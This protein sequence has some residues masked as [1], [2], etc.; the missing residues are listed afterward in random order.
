MGETATAASGTVQVSLTGGHETS[1]AGTHGNWVRSAQK[2]LQSLSPQAKCPAEVSL[3]AVAP[4]S[5]EPAAA[6]LYAVTH[7][8]FDP[9]RDVPDPATRFTPSFLGY[10]G[11]PH[12]QESPHPQAPKSPKMSECQKSVEKVPEH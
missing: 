2:W 12:I 6:V 7:G 8:Q 5:W 11:N 4:T 1:A 3:P 9:S 10:N